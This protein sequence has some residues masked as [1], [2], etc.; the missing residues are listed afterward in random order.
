MEVARDQTLNEVRD[1]VVTAWTDARTDEALKAEVDA[2]IAELDAGKPFQDL[3][4]ERN[5]FATLSAPITRDG[6]GTTILNQAV[7]TNVFSAGPDSHGWAVNG[8]GDYLVYHVTD[9]TPPT[10]EASPEIKDFLVNATRDA[11][12]A[13][14]ITGLTDEMWPQ[15]ARAGAYQRMLQLLTTIQ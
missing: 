1:A 12:Y 8:D 3:A 9:V 2:I 7:A 14:F 11:L 15:S 4:A 13:D 10:T 6:D 5:Q